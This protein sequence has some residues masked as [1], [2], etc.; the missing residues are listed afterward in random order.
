MGVEDRL[1]DVTSKVNLGSTTTHPPVSSSEKM[2]SKEKPQTITFEGTK[3]RVHFLWRRDREVDFVTKAVELRHACKRDVE[4][5]AHESIQQTHHFPLPINLTFNFLSARF[6]AS[7]KGQESE[8]R[9]ANF[10]YKHCLLA[11][12]S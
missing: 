11:D 4:L 7:R 2:L 6:Y 9:I 3:L 1:S 5:Y 10:T 12:F 8:Q